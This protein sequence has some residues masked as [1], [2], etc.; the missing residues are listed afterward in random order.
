M[1]QQLVPIERIENR[2][3]L[4]R[5]QKVMMDRDLA[6]LYGVETGQ[7]NRAV[8]RNI[9]R[10]PSDF[11][12]PLTKGEFENL[13]CQFGISSWGGARYRPRAFTEQGVAMLSSVLRSERA[14]QVNI[15]IM[16][17]FVKMRETIIAHKDLA[18]KLDAME[19]KYDASFRIVFDAIRRFMKQPPSHLKGKVGFELKSGKKRKSKA[20]KK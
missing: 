8:T 9:D 19:E 7:L 5:D 13:R 6:E 2:I 11:M 12:F 3:F 16:R 15:L 4:I 10:F 1:T 17:A 20:K 18:R 14:A